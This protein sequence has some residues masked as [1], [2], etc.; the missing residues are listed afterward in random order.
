MVAGDV[1]GKILYFADT[2]N[3][4]LLIYEFDN[5]KGTLLLRAFRPYGIDTRLSEE[6]PKNK[7]GFSIDQVKKLLERDR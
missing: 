6:L 1:D 4:R 7:D 5:N 2:H 3:Q